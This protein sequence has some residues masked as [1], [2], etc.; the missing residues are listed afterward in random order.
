MNKNTISK[1]YDG[2]VLFGSIFGSL[3]T[4]NQKINHPKHDRD[5]RN[6]PIN[7]RRA[8]LFE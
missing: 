3:F 8:L 2:T 7:L 1:K 6:I 4:Q 5:I